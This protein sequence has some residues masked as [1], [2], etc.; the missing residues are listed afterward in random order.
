MTELQGYDISHH[1][2][3]TP[4]LAGV[5]FVI[6]RA[7][8]GS[9][10]DERYEQHVAAARAA[11]KVVGAY[12]FA[13]PAAVDPIDAQASTFLRVS[14]GAD[15][16]AIDREKDGAS[17]VITA[18]DTRKM[19]SL[20]QASGRRVGLYASESAYRD[21]GQDWTW[22]AHWGTEPAI[23]W[24]IWQWDGGGTDG[25]DNDVFRGSLGG[26]R[27]LGSYRDEYVTGLADTIASLRV[28]VATVSSDLAAARATIATQATQVADL[29]DEVASLTRQRD[30]ERAAGDALRQTIDQATVALAAD[31]A[32]A[33]HSILTR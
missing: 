27:A 21:F 10:A 23:P 4:D 7:A 3:A 6:V 25:I 9:N 5:A 31:P 17:G 32:V 30:L 26:L 33:A 14:R 2:T 13:R 19:V 11:G 18:A 1:Q 20:V 8:Y 12:I 22:P 24:D 28:T 15:F 29:T 16:L